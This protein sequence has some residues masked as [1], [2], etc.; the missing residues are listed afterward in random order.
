M[1]DPTWEE[2]EYKMDNLKFIWG[3]KS[4]D[5]ITDS[6]ANMWT[7]N[8]IEID[9]DRSSEMYLLGI[10]TSYRFKKDK[11]GE[12]EYLES[13]LKAF[14]DFMKRNGYEMNEPYNFWEMQHSSLWIA[15]SI[16]KLYTNFRVFVEGYRKVYGA[17]TG[18]KIK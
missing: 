11:I 10:E 1:R 5:D 15:N 8:D 2:D 3:V 14:T 12:V 9:Y 4:W 16:P 17:K 18:G 6:K 7:M 13:L